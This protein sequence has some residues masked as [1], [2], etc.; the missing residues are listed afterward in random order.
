MTRVGVGLTFFSSSSQQPNNQQPYHITLVLHFGKKTKASSKISHPTH[1]SVTRHSQ[2]LRRR[3]THQSPVDGR[4]GAPSCL[5]GV[6]VDARP[7]LKTH[8]AFVRV[9][10]D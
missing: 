9:R 5:I 7:T 10:H 2:I 6:P 4:C 1:L 3:S 8:A